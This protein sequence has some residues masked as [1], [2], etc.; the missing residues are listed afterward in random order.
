[1]AFYTNTIESTARPTLL[2]R[3][4]RPIGQFFD[5]LYDARNRTETVARMQ[6]LTDADLKKLGLRRQDIVRHV[7]GDFNYL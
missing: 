6:N 1:M 4:L 3:L 7:Y 2:A 5:H